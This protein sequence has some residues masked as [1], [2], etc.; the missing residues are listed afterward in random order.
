MQQIMIGVVLTGH[1]RRIQQWL[2]KLTF[3]LQRDDE[4]RAFPELALHAH[5]PAHQLDQG[6]AY[7]QPQTCPSLINFLVL[8]QARKVHE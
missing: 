7:A 2:L 5:R 4:G 3:G 6:L 1:S 8:F